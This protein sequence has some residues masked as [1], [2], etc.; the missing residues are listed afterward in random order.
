MPV[1]VFPDGLDRD[2][3]PAEQL[4]QPSTIEAAL[5]PREGQRFAAE[6][7]PSLLRAARLFEDPTQLLKGEFRLKLRR[8]VEVGGHDIQPGEESA[9]RLPEPLGLL[10]QATRS[11]F[12]ESLQIHPNRLV[13]S[14]ACCAI[15]R[16]NHGRLATIA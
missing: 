3:V 1:S 16:E 8:V 12:A 5:S 11:T 7:R 4:D 14:A 15:Y 6:D 13:D 2:P 10:V 9:E